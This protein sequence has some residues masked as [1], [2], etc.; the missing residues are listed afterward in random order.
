MKSKKL[1]SKKQSNT[2]DSK[3]LKNFTFFVDRSSGKYGLVEGLQKLGLNVERHDDHFKP[4]TPDPEWLFE[5][6]RRSWVVISSDLNIKKNILEKQ[7][8][9]FSK[10]ASFF[11][12]SPQF[13][14][15]Q[16][17]QAFGKGLRKIIN[18]VI[19]QQRP[20]IA[21]IAKDGTIELW[22]DDKGVDCIQRKLEHRKLKKLKRRNRV[23]DDKRQ[24]WRTLKKQNRKGANQ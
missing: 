10:V 14:A 21:R 9:L 23:F 16:Q 15:E 8:L 22:V 19:S 18:Y 6:G 3:L 24:V 7:V 13:T 1:K 17:I 11:F 20:F 2:K 5:C 12:T 4:T